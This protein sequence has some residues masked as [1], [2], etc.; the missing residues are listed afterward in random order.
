MRL[1][2]WKVL[3]VPAHTT[4]GLADLPLQDGDFVC[5]RSLRNIVK[6]AAG[7]TS[8]GEGRATFSAALV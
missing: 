2:H 1:L 7:C 4:A 3:C 6:T 5:G 8:S